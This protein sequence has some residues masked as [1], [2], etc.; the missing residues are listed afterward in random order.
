MQKRT[1]AALAVLAIAIAAVV[2]ILILAG[3]DDEGGGAPVLGA[4]SGNP[5]LAPPTDSWYTNGGSIFN[6]R[7]SPLEE[8]DS[9]NVDQLRGE[10]QID[11]ES[12]EAIKYSAET[13]P[14]YDKGTLYVS[15]GEND[16]LAIDVDSGETI[17]RYEGEL[18]EKITTVCCGWTNRGVA[19]SDDKVFM[20]KL[21]ATLVALDR[22]TGREVWSTEV[23]KW[24]NG[25]TI[26]NAPLYYNGMVITG[27]SGGEFGIRGRVTA[28]DAE[29]GNERW[30]FNTIPGP[31]E[32]GHETWPQN[33]E[34]WKRGGAPVWHTPAVDPELGLL[35]F[36]AGNT[37]P[38]F[39]GSSRAGDNLFANSIIAVDAQTGERKWHFQQVHHGIWDYDPS[40][41]PVL[42]D[43]SYDGEMRQGIAQAS[44]TGWVYILDRETGE[45]LVG[46]EERPVP[47]NKKQHTSEMQPFPEGDSFVPQEIPREEAEQMMEE[48]GEEREWDYTNGGR[49]FTPFYGDRGIIAKPGTLGGNNWPPP[50]FSPQTGYLYV[51]GVDEAAVFTSTEVEYDPQA[52]REGE[53][54]LG[55]AFTSP[56]GAKR[57]G[58]F[59]A[60]DLRDNTIAWQKRWDNAC[61]SGSVATGGG[62]VFTGHNDGRLIA[63]DAENGEELWA[64][65]TGA[66][67]NAPATVF[68]HEGRQ[69]IAFYA[70][71]NS[72]IGSE[73][74]DNLWLFSLDGDIAS[75]GETEAPEEE[76][77]EQKPESGVEEGE[78]GEGE[79]ESENENG[80]TG[81]GG[82][83]G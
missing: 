80:G 40:S 73:H 74:D 46:I 19:I 55:S 47:Q 50:S 39:D 12:A 15:T 16:L 63:H 34:A 7:Y 44:K 68:E 37:S 35:Y 57:R 41:P 6:Q 82:T 13:Q 20:G 5:L 43:L 38:D 24:Q 77:T 53:E 69:H 70:G 48:A 65:D 56:E 71:G 66:G 2:G 18:N 27:L 22:K 60:M 79:E 21:D 72:L 62:L 9:E 51:C 25:E 45:P 58:T 4:D 67:A 11:L 36:V 26:T 28:Y 29:T 54:F 75:G 8:I 23:G 83:S 1:G 32:E 17:W 78:A 49:I 61:Y 42:F 81:H 64:F 31:D 30:R 33:N 3:E 10:W 59:T 14:I 52:V 76:G